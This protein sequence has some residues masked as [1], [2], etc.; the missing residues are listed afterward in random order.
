ML[1]FQKL[2][3]EYS[4]LDSHHQHLTML[5][6]LA[7]KCL[8]CCHVWMPHGFDETLCCSKYSSIENQSKQKDHYKRKNSTPHSCLQIR[9]VQ[10]KRGN[11][12]GKSTITSTLRRIPETTRHARMRFAAESYLWWL[13]HILLPL[14][15]HL[16]E[17]VL[18]V[19]YIN[20]LR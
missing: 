8:R 2:L 5:C 10:S 12:T 17:D 16:L 14:K 13:W 4:H 1:F 6:S 19:S 20:P 7:R 9:L 18:E 3:S 15:L 11:E